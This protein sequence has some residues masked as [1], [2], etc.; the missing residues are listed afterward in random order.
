DI[1][2]NR[3]AAAE[4]AEQPGVEA[5]LDEGALNLR[6][7][8]GAHACVKLPERWLGFHLDPYRRRL[9]AMEGGAP[10]PPRAAGRGGIP[11]LSSRGFFLPSPPP[12]LGAP[13]PPRGL[14]IAAGRP[15]SL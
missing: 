1:A 10:A 15:V 9:F 12:P 4:V 3:I 7:A 5:V 11:V 6:N 13:G 14:A 2:S 8:V